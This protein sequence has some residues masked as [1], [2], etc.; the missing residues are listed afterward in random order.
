LRVGETIEVDNR[1][2]ILR[3]LGSGRA[4]IDFNHRLAGK[5]LLYDVEIIKMLE[6]DKEKI[7]ALTKR[8]L[9]IDAEKIT[10]IIENGALKI[11]LP[12]ESYLLEGIQIT[13]KAI[14]S[15]IFKF[16]KAIQKVIFIEE[17][18]APK[19]EAAGTATESSS[20]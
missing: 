13:K 4:Q 10:F 5:T 14:S 11:Q 20:K 12:S 9:P 17:Y 16:L 1:I 18:E 19:E 3:S 15:D 6:S 2:G 8:R 7:T